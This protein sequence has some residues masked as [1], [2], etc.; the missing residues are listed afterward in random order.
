[1]VCKVVWNRVPSC[2]VVSYGRFSDIVFSFSKPPLSCTTFQLSFL[3][4][5][6]VTTRVPHAQGELTGSLYSYNS[7]E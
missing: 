5:R 7:F 3:T 1:M 4:T 6:I 2:K